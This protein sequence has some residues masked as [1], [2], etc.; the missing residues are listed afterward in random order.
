MYKITQKSW[1][2]VRLNPGMHIFSEGGNFWY[3]RYAASTVLYC[4]VNWQ[5]QL[6]YLGGQGIMMQIKHILGPL[7]HFD[8]LICMDWGGSRYP[9]FGLSL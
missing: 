1:S 7:L 2:E 4:A 8:F 5:H 9:D 3:A 6:L